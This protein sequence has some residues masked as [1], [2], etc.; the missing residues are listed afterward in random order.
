MTTRRTA[1]TRLIAALTATL[2]AASACGGGASEVTT[3]AT[4]APVATTEARDAGE[5]V[6]TP[7]PTDPAPT[8]ST[9]A[10]PTS[11]TEGA[12]AATAQTTTTAETSTTAVAPGE[13]I[14]T[15]LELL[16]I[17][18]IGLGGGSGEYS[19]T[20]AERPD[21]L[22]RFKVSTAGSDGACN[23]RI[24]D[25]QDTAAGTVVTVLTSP[26]PDAPCGGS[27]FGIAWVHVDGR[28]SGITYRDCSAG[29][30]FERSC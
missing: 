5:P 28:R 23:A 7:A 13:Q 4:D 20:V 27:V 9:A 21:G 29:I 16:G 2:I 24:L 11:S 26:D 3:D 30:T 17:T 10:A 22:E 1:T 8:T 25:V 19:I 18:S 15:E 14:A 12:V 6:A